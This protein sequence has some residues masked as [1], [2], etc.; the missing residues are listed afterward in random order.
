MLKICIVALFII[1]EKLR[2]GA[3]SFKSLVMAGNT[4][5]RSS[6]F[7]S[8]ILISFVPFKTLF[9]KSL[10]ISLS[11]FLS[12]SIS[13]SISLYLF[14]WLYPSIHSYLSIYL[15]IYQLF[16]HA[17]ELT[18]QLH[19]LHIPILCFEHFTYKHLCW[20]LIWRSLLTWS[21]NCVGGMLEGSSTGT[22]R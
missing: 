18:L 19:S 17:T 5:R 2:W 7:V 11:W 20:I 1:I 21:V 12:F 10:Y 22:K 13:F 15:S 6:L 16:C 4:W 8:L 3:R 9:S 14:V